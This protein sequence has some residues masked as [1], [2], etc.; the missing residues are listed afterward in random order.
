MEATELEVKDI[1][2]RVYDGEIV[3]PE[4]Q[5]SF[6]WEPEDI[7]QLL[8]SVL[9]SYFIGSIFAMDSTRDESPFA[10]RLI[11][12]VKG[13]NERAKIQS[14][15]RILLD[16]QQRITS[17][18]YALY[19]VDI[20]LKGRKYSY[21]FFLDL[22]SG[23]HEEWDKAVIS[24]NLNDK[25]KLNELKNKDLI[26]P[27]SQIKS[28]KDLVN[29]FSNYPELLG[30]IVELTNNFLNY[31]IHMIILPRG[32]ELSRVVETFEKLNR[33]GEPLS[34]FDL[35]TAK[36]YK[37]EVNLRDI[38][39]KSKIQ[40]VFMK[41]VPPESVLKVIALMRGREPKQKNL[42]EL[43][44]DN[45]KEDWWIACE[46]LE[47]AYKR[48]L[49]VKDG[50]GVLDF[51]KWMPYSTMI[52]PLAVMMHCV[53][54]RKI[55]NK[56]NYERIDKW[57]WVSVFSNRYDQAIDTL[58]YSDFKEMTEWIENG[59]EPDF[60]KEFD[61]EKVDLDTDKQ[62]SAIYRGVMNLIVLKGAYDFK[63]GQPPQ[64]EENKIQDDHIFP[65]SIFKEN[66]LTNR[67]LIS[68]NQAK[69]NK[70]PSEYFC[71]RIKEMGQE[72]VKDILNSH[73]ISE[74]ALD[75]LIKDN[76]E[77][78]LKLRKRAIIDEIRRKVVVGN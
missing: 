52:V 17:L 8:V 54:D 40:F 33:W 13:V 58:T 10:L 7:R 16:G 9:G 26:V 73:L 39:E 72:R 69:I 68:T 51:K 74:E 50:Y 66:R 5:R 28:I 20:P 36:L 14:S 23:I 61:P 76:L 21:R 75:S 62:S 45:F 59:I 78:F 11:E 57:Y 37:Y 24:V 43:E 31:K 12:G 25:R 49:D 64:F 63:T 48:I 18:F 30:K 53:K 60:I 42:L 22:D 55:E 46:A 44:S 27:F 4:F 3:L 65:K 19:D 15:I 2:N 38:L 34:T 71:E 35:L 56:Q 6:I 1:L 47:D 29:K 70:R 41:D 77:D 32:V 67:T